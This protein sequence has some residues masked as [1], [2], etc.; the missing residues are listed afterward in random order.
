[1]VILL[2]LTLDFLKRMWL[3]YVRQSMMFPR[4]PRQ[5]TH[6]WIQVFNSQLTTFCGTAEYIA[7][8]LLKGQKYGA[9]VDW[10]SFG[11]LLY[12]MMGFRTP[13]YDKNRKVMFHGI[14]NLEPNFPPHFTSASKTLLLKLLQKEPT[15]RLGRNGA[16]EIRGS[17]FFSAIDFWKLSMRMSESSESP[18]LLKPQYA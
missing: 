6:T 11:I 8:E 2:S 15:H 12:E 13:F 5:H 16:L 18:F 7:P 10:W 3:M 14:I 4:E 9:S 1:M 17:E